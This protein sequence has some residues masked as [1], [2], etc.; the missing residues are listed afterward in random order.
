LRCMCNLLQATKPPSPA[1]RFRCVRWLCKRFIV[2][3]ICTR[4]PSTQGTGQEKD[5]SAEFRISEGGG[6][7]L[8]SHHLH[9]CASSAPILSMLVLCGA[10]AFF[11]IGASVRRSKGREVLT[12]SPNIGHEMS[13][14][15]LCS[16][17]C[18]TIWRFSN[19]RLGPARHSGLLGTVHGSGG[20]CLDLLSVLCLRGGDIL[21]AVSPQAPTDSLPTG[22]SHGE[23]ARRR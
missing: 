21:S 11:A 3:S 8:R 7:Y 20:A 22:T 5:N 14:N 18:V 2:E 12:C 17:I 10:Y 19:P 1:G 13:R 9:H 23:M 6:C 4:I 16:Y 15:V